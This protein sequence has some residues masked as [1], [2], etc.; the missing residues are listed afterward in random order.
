MGTELVP[1]MSENLHILMQ[2]SAWENFIGLLRLMKMNM[3]APHIT[4]FVSEIIIVY[5]LFQLSKAI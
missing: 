3:A 1:K 2:L 4:S 5:E